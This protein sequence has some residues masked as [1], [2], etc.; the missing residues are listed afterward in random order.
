MG[1]WANFRPPGVP[2]A[3]TEPEN[4]DF[5]ASQAVEN[6]GGLVLSSFVQRG[7]SKPEAGEAGFLPNSGSLGGFVHSGRFV[8]GSG[9]IDLSRSPKVPPDLPLHGIS[10][11]HSLCGGLSGDAAAGQNGQNGQNPSRGSEP[12]SA[13]FSPQPDGEREVTSSGVNLLD[14][15][16]A[17]IVEYDGGIPREW[18]EGF[19][20]LRPDRPAH[21]V[22]LGR[23][24][25]FLDDIGKFLDGGWAAEAWALGWGPLDLFGCSRDKPLGRVDSAGL[26]WM[27]NGGKLVELDRHKAVIETGTGARQ[28]FRRRPLAVGEAALAWEI[29]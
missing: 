10:M 23:W 9:D 1:R 13:R 18:A 19:A 27:L 6:K 7:W 22:P 8:H 11:D 24:C 4:A 2:K 5:G 20:R 28:T 25:R 15:E 3:R 14:E 29:A 26:L 17:A 21:G 16:P 12:P